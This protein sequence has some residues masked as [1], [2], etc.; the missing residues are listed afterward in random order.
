MIGEDCRIGRIRIEYG[1]IAVKLHAGPH[2]IADYDICLVAGCSDGDPAC[3]DMV[4]GIFHLEYLIDGK[5]GRCSCGLYMNRKI[6]YAL[7]RDK[8]IF[9]SGVSRGISLDRSGESEMTVAV[10]LCTEIR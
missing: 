8:D 4:I 1:H 6:G 10:V 2:C 7:E 3:V 5:L 9:G